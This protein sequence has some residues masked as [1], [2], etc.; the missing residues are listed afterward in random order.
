ME[1]PLSL[2]LLFFF[3]CV[4][5]LVPINFPVSIDIFLFSVKWAAI[6]FSVTICFLLSRVNGKQTWMWAISYWNPLDLREDKCT[7]H[8]QEWRF[9][10]GLQAEIWIGNTEEGCSTAAELWLHVQPSLWC[11]PADQ[12]VIQQWLHKFKRNGKTLKPQLKILTISGKPL[13]STSDAYRW[14]VKL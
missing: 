1:L 13:E 3:V 2:Q 5:S 9:C 12:W 10:Q 7:G 8:W 14:I 4:D 11:V 6:T